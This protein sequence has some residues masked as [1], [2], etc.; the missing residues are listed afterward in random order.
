[1]SG[2]ENEVVTD[3]AKQQD[4]A[5]V[6]GCLVNKSGAV[7]ASGILARAGSQ[8]HWAGSFIVRQADRAWRVESIQALECNPCAPDDEGRDAVMQAVQLAVNLRLVV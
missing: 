4:Q 5:T 3:E 6:H 7:V 8:S 2:N 1:M